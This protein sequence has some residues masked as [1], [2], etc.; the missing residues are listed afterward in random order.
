M[1]FFPRLALAALALF[2]TA[3]L[4]GRDST[5]RVAP[6]LTTPEARDTRSRAEPQV[7]RVTHVDLDLAADFERQRV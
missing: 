1:T 2:A 3:P 4:L 7:A 5:P 6:I